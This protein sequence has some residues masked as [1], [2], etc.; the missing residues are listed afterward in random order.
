MPLLTSEG[1]RR[2]FVDEHLAERCLCLLFVFFGILAHGPRLT[3][4][5]T[6]GDFCFLPSGLRGMFWVLFFSIT[7]MVA[8]TSDGVQVILFFA[9]SRIGG[10]GSWD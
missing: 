8:N 10:M 9:S 7:I 5:T 4:R 3:R 1:N 2:M 6:D